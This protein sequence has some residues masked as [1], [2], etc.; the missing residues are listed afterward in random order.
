MLIYVD[1]IIL[2]ESSSTYIKGLII[3]LNSKFSLK[4]LGHLHFFLGVDLHKYDEKL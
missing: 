2:I 4:D 3:L 1:D